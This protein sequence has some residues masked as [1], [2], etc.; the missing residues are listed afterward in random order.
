MD[1]QRPSFGARCDRQARDAG[2]HGVA[3][4]SGL[5]HGAAERGAVL[6]EVE[7]G[8]GG[9]VGM[10][11]RAPSMAG[12]DCFLAWWSTYPRMSASP[13]ATL[14]L[15]R[16]NAQVDIRDIL[17]SIRVPALILHRAQ[18]RLLTVDGARY[19]AARIPGAKYVELSGED[20]VWWVGD[21]EAILDEV[22]LFLNGIR[23]GGQPD[24]VLATVM[25][26]T[27]IEGE[28]RTVTDDSSRRLDGRQA[29][30]AL[31]LEEL[32]RQRGQEVSA[33]DDS[34]RAT[35]DGPARAIRCACAI[36]DAM[37]SMG[38]SVAVGLHTGECDVLSG[39]LGGLAFRI[40]EQVSAHAAL[41]EV[42]V[43]GT[44]RDLVAGSGIQVADRG[45]H[46]FKDVPGQ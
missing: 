38:L 12:N 43:S 10:A 31:V 44:V 13:G 28:A 23:L 24:R 41:D 22:D 27:I 26:M 15:M 16:M 1:E 17:P 33:T 18:D 32:A 14:A 37:R 21:S 30:V 29:H 40:A 39:G 20:H 7:H 46:V 2:V 8:W 5:P 36:R 9:P 45:T 6:V 3:E 34:F 25:V 11:I 19:M 42:L 4:A 35:F